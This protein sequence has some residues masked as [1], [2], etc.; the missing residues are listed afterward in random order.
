MACEPMSQ[1]EPEKSTP[2]LSPRRMKTYTGGQGYVYQYYFV[3]RRRALADD[4]D[5][6]AWEYI[7]D[8]T[9]DLKTTFAVSVFVSEEVVRQ[10]ETK[11]Q[12]KLSQAEQYGAVK[13]RLFR[14][15]DEVED[16]LNYGRRLPINGES[17]Q[18]SLDSLGVE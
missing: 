5:A 1:R 17:L 3:G 7:F 18:Q 11:H 10:W 13:L 6:P 8:V 15:F 4:S 14:A 2:H 16:M 12:R 9:S